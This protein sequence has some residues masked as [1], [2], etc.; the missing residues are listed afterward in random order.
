MYGVEEI[1]M[2]V[3]PEEQMHFPGVRKCPFREPDEYA[4]AREK[5]VVKARLYNE[6][7]VWFV[8]R[9]EDVSQVLMDRRFS[10]STA[11]E[12]F[13]FI[14]ES[15]EKL[16]RAHPYVLSFIDP[17]EHT[18]LRRLFAPMFTIRNMDAFR[19]RLEA[20]VDSLITET[21]EKGPPIN[22]CVDFSLR[23]T[24]WSIVEIMGLP[25]E[26]EHFFH[27]CSTANLFHTRDPEAAANAVTEMENYL[28]SFIAAK[29]K[30]PVDTDDIISRLVIDNILPGR[31]SRSVVT[32]LLANLVLNGQ[33][34]T[35]NMISLG[36]LALLAYPDEREKLLSRP[37][38]LD[39]AIDEMLRFFTIAIAVAPRT[40]LEDLEIGA[41]A[42]KKGD[43]VIG[44]VLSGNWDETV[45]EN[46][47]TFKIDRDNLSQHLAFGRGVHSCIGRPLALT[48]LKVV[49]SR[50][51]Q[52]IPD[53]R[54]AVSVED[55]EGTG[56]TAQ[57]YG[58]KAL[59]VTW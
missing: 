17:P 42:V 5:G 30:N 32:P 48:E 2:G 51:F 26:D 54:L 28:D 33:D 14:S 23:V 27:A 37:E 15:R 3:V 50:L 36:T 46:A 18:G 31:M 49:F 45:F 57:A 29:E 4:T 13:P 53:L 35:G 47:E 25:H 55:V 9:H 59:P 20:F 34:T 58:L 10:S 7:P 24:I 8:S 38:L 44:C 6:K 41:Q 12:N 40:A 16:Q 39:N 56:A 19:P 22:M 43:G 52:A 1:L 11:A 21:L